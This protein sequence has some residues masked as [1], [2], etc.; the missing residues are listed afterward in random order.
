MNQKRGDPL[1][2]E[3]CFSI[4]TLFVLVR[5]NKVEKV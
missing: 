3:I 5:K 4:D 2:A 1:T